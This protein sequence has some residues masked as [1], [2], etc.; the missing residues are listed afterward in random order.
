M[1]VLNSIFLFGLSAS[2]IFYFYLKTKQFHTLQVYPIR[3]KMYASLAGIPLGFLLIFFALNQFV[4]FDG[5][6]T[7]VVGIIFIVY[8]IYMAVANYKKYKHYEQFIEEET[9]LNQK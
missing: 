3:K 1:K 9:R 8:G 7:Y 6:I 2:F 4:L 5:W